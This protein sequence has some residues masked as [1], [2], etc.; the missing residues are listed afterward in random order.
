[1]SQGYLL[2]KSKSFA[3]WEYFVGHTTVAI[4]FLSKIYHLSFED[5]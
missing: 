3:K 1:M 4:M 2:T 5:Y